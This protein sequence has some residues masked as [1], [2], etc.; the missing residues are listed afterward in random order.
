MHVEGSDYHRKHRQLDVHNQIHQDAN[1]KEMTTL[2]GIE[3]C[4]KAWTTRSWICI[5]HHIIDTRLMH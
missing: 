5:D 2:D 3:V 4:P 1:G